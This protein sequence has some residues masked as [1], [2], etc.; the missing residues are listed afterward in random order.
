MADVRLNW[1]NIWTNGICASIWENR[2]VACRG[3]FFCNCEDKERHMQQDLLWLTILNFRQFRSIPT[4]TRGFS[5]PV[6]LLVRV[7]SSHYALFFLFF[8]LIRAM[9]TMSIRIEET[10]NVYISKRIAKVILSE[11]E[12]ERETGSRCGDCL[13]TQGTQDLGSGGEERCLLS[14]QSARWMEDTL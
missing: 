2:I 4:E 6:D 14:R 8:L 9:I 7:I 1:R 11:G 13:K 12:S 10:A 3:R 5:A